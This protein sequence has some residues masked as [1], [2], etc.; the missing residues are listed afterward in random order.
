MPSD[1]LVPPQPLD[2]VAWVT[3]RL[4]QSGTISTSGTVG[5]KKMALHLL[6]QAKDAI[7][8]RVPD[9]TPAGLVIPGR[10]V[11][12]MPSVPTR[13]VGDMAPGERGDP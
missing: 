9:P 1:I 10:D 5:D 7:K 11:A 2:V 13:D 6:D 3:V 8:G 12:V 4:H